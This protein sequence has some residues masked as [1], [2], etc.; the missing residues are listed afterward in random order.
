MP[1]LGT[2]RRVAPTTTTIADERRIAAT[3][4]V[5]GDSQ[6]LPARRRPDAK[7]RTATGHAPWPVD[8]GRVPTP[9]KRADSPRLPRSAGDA[10]AR[11]EGVLPEDRRARTAKQR[12]IGNPVNVINNLEKKC[13]HSCQAWSPYG[14]ADAVPELPCRRRRR[15]AVLRAS[16]GQPLPRAAV[17][18][19]LI[20]RVLAGKY[21]VVQLLGE[22]GMGSVYLAEQ[23]LGTTTRKVAI[24]TLHSHLSRDEGIRERFQREVGTLAGLEHPNTVQ[25]Y[26][27]G[28]T[29]EEGLL[30]IAM[31]YVQGKSLADIIDHEG[32]LAPDRVRKI[33]E[34]I[35]GSLAEAHSQ[36]IVHRDLKPDNVILTDRAGQKDFV[37]VLD[38]GIAKRSKEAASKEKKL[39]QQGMVLGTPPYMSPEQFT[40]QLGR[41]RAAT[42][43]RSRSWRTRCSPAS[44]RSK[45]RARSSGRRCT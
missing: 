30:F 5:R 21:K 16:C 22:G 28:T 33:I 11:A 43:I 45:L 25:V 31:E 36:G 26:D 40:G 9:T 34:E 7:R 13:V 18:D 3:E 23:Q 12:T 38:F 35:G 42:S 29:P 10:K 37:K 15:A 8:E 24:K 2:A 27:F 17:A 1:N 4:R 6:T 44:C 20:G 32:A 39:T 14:P 41:C 19:P